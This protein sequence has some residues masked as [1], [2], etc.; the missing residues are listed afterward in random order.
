MTV[1]R[2]DDSPRWNRPRRCV[3]AVAALSMKRSHALLQAI[4]ST[5]SAITSTPAR[6]TLA[7]PPQLKKPSGG[8]HLPPG[9]AFRSSPTFGPS[10]DLRSPAP[11]MMSDNPSDAAFK[12]RGEHFWHPRGP[13]RGSAHASG[14]AHLASPPLTQD[15]GCNSL[16]GPTCQARRASGDPQ[17]H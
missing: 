11:T 13:C 17:G 10:A 15:T 16:P 4:T 3:L 12:F 8:G 6:N 2:C 5:P 1:P 9:W 7:A 14:G